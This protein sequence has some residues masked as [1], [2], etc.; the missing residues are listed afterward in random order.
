VESGPRVDLLTRLNRDM[1]IDRLT[2]LPHSATEAESIAAHAGATDPALLLLGADASRARFLSAELVRF[3]NIHFAGHALFDSIRPDL[4]GLIFSLRA[5]DGGSLPGLVHPNDLRDLE[6]NAE[7]ITLSACRTA[8]GP[9]VKG[10]GLL[11]VTRGLMYAGARRVLVSSWSVEDAAT[12]ELMDRFYAAYLGRGAT[13][14][15][16]LRSA[17]LSMRED[18]DWPSTAYWGAFSLHGDWR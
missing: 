5:S 13:P 16:A 3:R 8:W 18:P 7:L 17:K 10:E 9:Q 2:D 6:L 15:A 1:A 14:A 11:G 4:S 12:A